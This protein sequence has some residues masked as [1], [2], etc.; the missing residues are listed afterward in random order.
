MEISVLAY[1]KLKNW[2]LEKVYVL[3]TEPDWPN[4]HE[5]TLCVV[6]RLHSEIQILSLGRAKEVP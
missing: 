2:F 5:T 1:P 6:F 3:A 4:S